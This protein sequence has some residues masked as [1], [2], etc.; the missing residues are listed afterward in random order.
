MQHGRST[1]E[2]D[3]LAEP[4]RTIHYVR[5]DQIMPATESVPILL[6]CAIYWFLFGFFLS[7][8]WHYFVLFRLKDTTVIRIMVLEVFIAAIVYSKIVV[9]VT[10]KYINPSLGTAASLSVWSSLSPLVIA[11]VSLTMHFF[12]AWRIRQLKLY[13]R[14]ILFI[15]GMICLV[16]LT[17]F[18]ATVAIVIQFNIAGR[19]P[20]VKQSL[21]DMTT[22]WVTGGLICDILIT[23]TMT[24][25][26]VQARAQSSFS[27][28]SKAINKLISLSIE[29]AFPT[30]TVATGAL[31]AYLKY[32]GTNFD[33]CFM[34]LL[35]IA[36]VNALFA[37]L[38]RRVELRRIVAGPIPSTDIRAAVGS[39]K[40][41]SEA[42]FPYSPTGNCSFNLN[43][44]SLTQKPTH[45]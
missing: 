9:D 19:H 22:V 15:C 6:G 44:L 2:I 31:I 5:S 21:G 34:F 36:Y 29:T 17:Q 45:C 43:D 40:H 10:W 38:N 3:L 30:V 26:L 35:F 20:A 14:P 25:I 11:T 23:A 7:Q 16:S 18:G 39:N 33:V 28:T 37:V 13:S 1:Q 27:T 24:F 8:I 4:P 41:L 12:F 42:D 32:P